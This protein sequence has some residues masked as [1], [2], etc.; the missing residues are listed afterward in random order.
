[1]AY[2]DDLNAVIPYEDAYVFCQTFQTLANNIGLRLNKDKSKILT[3]I[4][5]KSV[6]PFL[7]QTSQNTLQLCLSQF[8]NNKE[9]T[10]GI[11]I[12]G[13]PIGSEDFITNTLKKLSSQVTNSFNNIQNNLDNIQ[14]VG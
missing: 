6:A 11:K 9:T 3:S 1:M 5:N 7:P 13:F 4:N 12:L 10:D 8:T 14:T 2:V